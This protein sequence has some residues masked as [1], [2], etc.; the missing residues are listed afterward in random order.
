MNIGI[1]G[2]GNIGSAFARALARN[3]IAATISNSRGPD[4]LQDLTEE[5]SPHITA[6]TIEEAAKADLVLVAV[7]WSKLHKALAGLPDWAGR[8]VIDANNP[9]EGPLFKPA[10]L[11]GRLSTEVFAGL[12]P[13]ARVVKAFNHLQAHL[14]STDPRAEGGSRVLFYSGDDAQSKAEVGALISKLGFAGIDLGPI[15]IGGKLAQFPGGPL[16]VLN[17]VKF[18]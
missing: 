13:G 8:I 3:G 11:N 1:I 18:G 5:L 2:A 17:L 10:E 12:V 4:T 7:P 16:P 9:I 14:V 15:S 6:G